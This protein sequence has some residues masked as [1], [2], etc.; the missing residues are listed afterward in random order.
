[1]VS[2]DRKD[3]RRR[4]V[5]EI[6][7]CVAA[8]AIY[9]VLYHLLPV[10]IKDSYGLSKGTGEIKGFT[11]FWEMTGVGYIRITNGLYYYLGEKREVVTYFHIVCSFLSFLFVFFGARKL[12]TPY[13]TYGFPLVFLCA[14]TGVGI[15]VRYDAW[16]LLLFGVSLL[17]YLVIHLLLALLS[18]SYEPETLIMTES[19]SE[20]EKRE[21]QAPKTIVNDRGETITLL[22]NPLPGPKKHVKR[23]LGYDLDVPEEQMFY[24]HEGGDGDD[25]DVV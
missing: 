5:T 21:S 23:T 14:E 3:R 7:Y 6:A 16:I 24:D 8:F 13:L 9:A 15:L 22:V 2:A 12:Y 17:F 18:V 11:D 4:L 1:M 25:Y 10:M 20:R 19:L